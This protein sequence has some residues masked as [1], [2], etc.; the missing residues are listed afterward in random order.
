MNYSIHGMRTAKKWTHS[1]YSNIHQQHG[2]SKA[3]VYIAIK[4]GRLTLVHPS[5]VRHR[6]NNIYH[7]SLNSKTPLNEM[8]KA[9]YWSN[10]G[11]IRLL[12]K[13][14][15]GNSKHVFPDLTRRVK[16]PRYYPIIYAWLALH[17]I[18]YSGFSY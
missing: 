9:A 18:V 17:I 5:L 14:N 10:G 1:K 3:S 12:V 8:I 7:L 6:L 4:K 2:Q 13:E 15:L 16:S 11:G